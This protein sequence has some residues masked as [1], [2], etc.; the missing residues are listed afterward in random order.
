MVVTVLAVAGLALTRPKT[1]TQQP[2]ERTWQVNTIQAD[3]ADHRPTL[4]LYGKVESPSYAQLTAAI[5]ADVKAV[6]VREASVFAA[7]ALLVELDD[8]EAQQRVAQRRAELAEVDAQIA[9]ENERHS[10][11]VAALPHE[12]Q[13]LALADKSVERIR[14]LEVK[15]LSSRNQLDEALQVKARQ[16]LSLLTRKAAIADH[17]MRLA[18]LEARRVQA[19]TRLELAELDLKRTRIVAPFAGRVARLSVAPGKRVRVG[20]GL[21]EIYDPGAL[22]LRAQVPM[23]VTATLRAALTAGSEVPARAAVDG[24]TISSQLVR[25]GTRVDAGSG[26]LDGFFRVDGGG[27]ALQVGRVVELLVDMPPAA[28]TFTVPHEALYGSDRIY[29]IVDGRLQ[30]VAVEVVGETRDLGDSAKLLLRSPEIRSGD[31]IV[32]TKF[33]NAIAGLRVVAD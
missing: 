12:Q 28:A 2:Q 33:A 11:D 17:P 16:E 8:R 6:P 13:L 4:V 29:T 20:D 21:L 31:P 30:P 26:G 1:A 7:A 15:E 32:T 5:E 27:S 10:N 18:Q 24:S 9:S 3:V 23:A 22:D 14:K 25:L 19:Q